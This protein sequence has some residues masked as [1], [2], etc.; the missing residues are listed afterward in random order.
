M[1]SKDEKS[2]ERGFISGSA[3]YTRTMPPREKVSSAP[4]ILNIELTLEEA[5]K[6]CL[7]ID[8]RCRKVNRYKMS[9]TEGKRARVGL[10]IHLDS[11]WIVAYEGK[12]KKSSGG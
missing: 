5:L 12:A 1:P 6:L 8:E 4:K 2:V 10:G 3:Q 11:Q 9:T 7:A